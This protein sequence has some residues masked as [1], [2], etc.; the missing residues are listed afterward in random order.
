VLI[1]LCRAGKLDEIEKWIASGRSIH[2]QPKTKK[3]PLQVAIDVGF[4]SLIELLV[5]NEDCQETKN[6]ALSAAVSGRRLDLVQLLVLYGAEITAVP[7]ADVLR[8]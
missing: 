2:T 8:T 1:A 4:H 3:T 6:R 5:R 7:L